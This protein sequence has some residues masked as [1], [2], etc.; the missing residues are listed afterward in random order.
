MAW[1]HVLLALC[2]NPGFMSVPTAQIW[3]SLDLF[4]LVPLPKVVTLH[5]L[6]FTTTNDTGWVV[7]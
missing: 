2:V 3:G 1:L 7:S 5:P 4:F 6:I